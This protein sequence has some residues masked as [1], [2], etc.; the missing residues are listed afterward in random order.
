MVLDVLEVH[1]LFDAGDLIELPKVAAQV[2]IVGDP[3]NVS[4]KVAEIDRIETHQGREQ[5]PIR[6]RQTVTDQIT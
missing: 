4:L 2:G 5:A 3:A 6:F 1:G